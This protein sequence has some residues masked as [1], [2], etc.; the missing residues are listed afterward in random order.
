MV[1]SEK[2]ILC[3]INAERLLLIKINAYSKYNKRD[4]SQY[5]IQRSNV[6]KLRDINPLEIVGVTD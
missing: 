2:W 6:Q 5:I 4:S 1:V 3:K